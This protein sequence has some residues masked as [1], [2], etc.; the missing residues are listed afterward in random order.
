[1]HGPAR[2]SARLSLLV[3]PE[4]PLV[5]AGRHTCDPLPGHALDPGTCFDNRLQQRWL[6]LTLTLTLS[7]LV[8]AL[9]PAVTLTGP[10]A[11]PNCQDVTWSMERARWGGTERALIPT[12]RKELIPPA[13]TGVVGRDSDQRNPL[14][15]QTP[16][17]LKL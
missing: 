17:P 6:S 3:L 5:L 10:P 9:R 14:P 16:D 1:M 13:T 11:P 2:H 15:C 8:A 7:F 12:A 4:G